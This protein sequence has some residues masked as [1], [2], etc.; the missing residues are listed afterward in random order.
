MLRR[1]LRIFFACFSLSPI[2]VVC[3]IL[4]LNPAHAA[5][6]PAER[7]PA[8]LEPFAGYDVIFAPRGEPALGADAAAPV[9][10]MLEGK[11]PA[12]PSG[13][14]SGD[15]KLEQTQVTW[16]IDC[17]G[18]HFKFLLHHRD[19]PN[20]PVKST[21]TVRFAILPLVEP[22]QCEGDCPRQATELTTIV[23]LRV[24]A[25]EAKVPWQ[26]VRDKPGSSADAWQTA[27][28][29]AHR[30]VATADPAVARKSLKAAVAARPIAQLRVTEAFDLLLLA[31][32][33]AAGLDSELVVQVGAASD[34]AD[35][36][37][38]YALTAFLPEGVTDATE[39]VQD[40]LGEKHRCAPDRVR[41]RDW[42]PLV[43][44]LAATRQFSMAAKL[45]DAIP[46]ARSVKQP[47]QEWLKLRFGLASALNDAVAEQA[48]ARRC[49][50]AWPDEPA[51]PDLLSAA[52]IRGKQYRLAI[53]TLHDLSLAHPERDIVL[54]KLAGMLNFLRG[55]A[56][57]DPKLQEDVKAIEARMSA[58]AKAN[59]NDIVA[60]FLDATRKYYGGHLIEALPELEALH[61][62][63][64]RDPR[65]PL[66]LAMTHFWLGHQKIAE[67]LIQD[68]VKIGPSDPDVFYCRSQIVRRWNLPQAVADMQRYVAMTSQPWSINAEK[69]DERV[70]AELDYMQRGVLPPDW[71]KPGP[72]RAVFDPKNQPG[73]PVSAAVKN[74]TATYET[75][76]AESAT[77]SQANTA[78][79]LAGDARVATETT[80]PPVQAQLREPHKRTKWTRNGVRNSFVVLGVLLI[81]LMFWRRRS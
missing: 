21:R 15:I 65:I 6:P 47:P 26:Q 25:G 58:A 59:P 55:A 37:Y 16:R 31:H 57:D 75:M 1:F 11:G 69:K 66:Y 4:H 34:V 30:A 80:M 79:S 81:A 44:A 46:L 8:L 28:N 19:A 40:C 74:G 24:L 17:G 61:K 52:L 71:D 41:P 48:V 63:D 76:L 49:I 22:V 78:T 9:E 68:A 7:P 45:L 29:D 60:R 32:E 10:V 64:N 50:A 5:D 27:L 23:R 13:C 73:T 77:P 43:R 39:Y 38:H 53:E 36:S 2:A 70:R 56:A 67:S 18:L 54:G 20:L 33:A 51:G 14:Y 42:L 35:S 62:T 12:L 72:E 3:S